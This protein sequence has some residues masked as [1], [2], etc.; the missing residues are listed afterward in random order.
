MIFR[1]YDAH[2]GSV[3]FFVHSFFAVVLSL[4][5]SCNSLVSLCLFRLLLPCIIWS[6]VG[7]TDGYA[8]DAPPPEL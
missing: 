6:D 4:F 8:A 2:S 3:G 7:D 5:V 1:S